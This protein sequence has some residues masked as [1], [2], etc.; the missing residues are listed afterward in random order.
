MEVIHH[1]FLAHRNFSALVE[2]KEVGHCHIVTASKTK[3]QAG[4]T[5]LGTSPY[6]GWK[7]ASTNTYYWKFI[8]AILLLMRNLGTHKVSE[9]LL[10]I[11]SGHDRDS[12]TDIDSIQCLVRSAATGG[13]NA[14]GLSAPGAS[15][16]GL[17]GAAPL[18]G[19]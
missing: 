17:S 3:T 13:K 1:H 18:N 11:G 10:L 15:V 4:S 2:S 16:W 8:C 6:H 12:G 14:R 7:T 5:T 9:A 19:R